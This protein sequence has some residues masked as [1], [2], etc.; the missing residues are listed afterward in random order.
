MCGQFASWTLANEF[1]PIFCSSTCV[2]CLEHTFFCAFPLPLPFSSEPWPLLFPHPPPPQRQSL[3]QQSPL[4]FPFTYLQPCPVPVNVTVTCFVCWLVGCG[5]G[6]CLLVSLFSI[7]WFA[8]MILATRIYGVKNYAEGNTITNLLPQWK[9][10]PA[11]VNTTKDR[12]SHI[13]QVI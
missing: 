10:Y 3:H 9:I 12:I 11:A 13:S 5:F 4:P 6:F 1:L 2:M 8:F 7:H